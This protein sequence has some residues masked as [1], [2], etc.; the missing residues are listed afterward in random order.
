M[1]IAS[2][3]AGFT[4]GEADI[5]RKAMGKK[6]VEVMAAQKDKFVKGSALRGVP[7]KKAAKVWDLMEQFA[8]YG[9]NK[10]HSAAYAWLAYQT[11]YLKANYPAFFMAALLTSERANTDKMVQYIGECREMG[12]RVLPPDVN[13]SDMFFTVVGDDIRFGLAAIKN[14]GEGAV[15]HVLKVRREDAVPLVLRLLRPRGPPGAEPPGGGELHQERLLRQPRPTPLGALRGHR[16][17]PGGGSQEAAGPRGRTV[18]PL[19]HAGRRRRRC[20]PRARAHLPRLRPGA[21]ANAWPARRNRSASSSPGIPWSGSGPSWSSGAAA[22][23]AAS[24]RARTPWR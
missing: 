24:L 16:P 4:L 10:S 14:V 21:R 1:Q 9:F 2:A 18:E 12:I 7:E 20:E 13:Q 6:K 23:P 17:R 22:P 19:R 8:G 5:L 11:A 3:M 15:D